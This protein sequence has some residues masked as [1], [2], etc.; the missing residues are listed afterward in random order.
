MDDSGCKLPFLWDIELYALRD[1]EYP[2]GVKLGMLIRLLKGRRIRGN[3]SV[4]PPKWIE[5]HD[6]LG[7]SRPKIKFT[8][9]YDTPGFCLI[10]AILGLAF[11][12]MAFASK[13][14]RDPQDIYNVDIPDR[15]QSVPIEWTEDWKKVPLL[16]RSVRDSIGKVYTSPKLASPF[17]QMSTWNR[18]LWR[19]F[20]MKENFELRCFVAA[21]RQLYQVS[22]PLS[23]I[24]KPAALLT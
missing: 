18:R 13:W 7:Y 14:I 19:S 4:S 22:F 10:K 2:G 8:E 12:D 20:G 16:R 6:W 24:R 9:C 1:N 17:N 5:H 3:P 11:R 21:R 23:L 15:L